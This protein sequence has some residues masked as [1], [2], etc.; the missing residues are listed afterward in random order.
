MAQRPRKRQPKG[1]TFFPVVTERGVFLEKL[2]AGPCEK[3][4]PVEQFSRQAKRIGGLRSWCKACEKPRQQTYEMKEEVKKRRRRSDRKYKNSE[5]G[6][7]SRSARDKTQGCV[8]IVQLMA[9]VNTLKI[10]STEH[11]SRRLGNL[12]RQYGELRLLLV[13]PTDTP[14]SLEENLHA[15]LKTFRLYEGA[16]KSELFRVRTR[17]ARK[18]LNGLMAQHSSC[19]VALPI[20]DISPQG[21]E[22]GQQQLR[23][24]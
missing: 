12:K 8:Y 9:R 2:C 11:L 16:K 19:V 10:G 21:A 3:V 22:D 17:A 23:F 6:K 24:L 4:K 20:W 15:H 14:R 18:A 7:A 1:G 13:I 5:K